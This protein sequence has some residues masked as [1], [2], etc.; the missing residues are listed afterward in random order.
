MGWGLSL[1]KTKQKKSQRL[2]EILLC[3]YTSEEQK[4]VTVSGKI[5]II[6]ISF[7]ALFSSLLLSILWVLVQCFFQSLF[8]FLWDLTIICE[9][10][11]ALHDKG[12]VV[13]WT[14]VLTSVRTFQKLSSF[15]TRPIP[16][17]SKWTFPSWVCFAH[18]Q[19]QVNYFS[20]SSSLFLYFLS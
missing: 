1:N 13:G 12:L 11:F 5:R 18:K 16:T 17:G 6:H 2:P 4:A 14:T 8:F 3:S 15:P 9:I 19:Y 20:L 10:V 7:I